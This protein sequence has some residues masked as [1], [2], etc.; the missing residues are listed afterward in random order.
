MR[1][2]KNANCRNVFIHHSTLVTYLLCWKYG[3]MSTLCPHWAL[4]ITVLTVHFNY[5]KAFIV[6]KS[7]LTITSHIVNFSKAQVLELS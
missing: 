5:T 1:K 3:T 2:V 6:P 4:A 7:Q